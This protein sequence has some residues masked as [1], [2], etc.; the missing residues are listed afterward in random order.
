MGLRH[1][2]PARSHGLLGLLLRPSPA[3]GSDARGFRPCGFIQWHR[4]WTKPQGKIFSFFFF[5]LGPSDFIQVHGMD[6][7]EKFTARALH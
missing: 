5:Y 7:L 3:Q 2:P 4:H 6:P 1:T